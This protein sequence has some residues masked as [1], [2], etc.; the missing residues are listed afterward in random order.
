MDVL[1]DVELGKIIQARAGEKEIEV[2]WDDL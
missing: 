2:D 1:E